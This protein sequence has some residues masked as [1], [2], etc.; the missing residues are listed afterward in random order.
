MSTDG[1]QRRWIRL[2]FYGMI[3]IVVMAIQLRTPWLTPAHKRVQG[4]AALQ[5][6]PPP[7]LGQANNPQN[8]TQ[9]P[10]PHTTTP[11]PT[12]TH[13]PTPVPPTATDTPTPPS[14]TVTDT[15]TPTDTHTRIPTPP[16]PATFTATPQSPT[17]TPKQRGSDGTR[18]IVTLIPW[19]TTPVPAA[20]STPP[21]LIPVTFTPTKTKT[22]DVSPITI[23]PTPP[24][25]ATLTPQLAP[26]TQSPT[27][28]TPVTFT[29]TPPLLPTVTPSPSVVLGCIGRFVPHDLAHVTTVESLQIGLFEAL[30]AGVAVSDLDN[31]DDLDI[32]LGGHD[33][34]DTILWNEGNLR[35]RW[36]PFGQGGT[37]A[38]NAVDV[39]GDGWLD[40][41]LTRHN[42]AVDFWRSLGEA[43]VD[44]GVIGTSEQFVLAV[45]PGIIAPA[46]AMSWGDLDGD[47]DLDLITAAY[48]AESV[49]N[50][51]AGGVMV[52]EHQGSSFAP[53]VL[54]TDTV[55]LALA[56]FDL[57]ADGQLDILV[58]NDGETPDQVWLRSGV[59]WSEGTPLAET[60]F[61]MRSFDWDDLDNDGSDELFT[62]DSNDGGNTLLQRRG[63]TFNNGAEVWGV[64]ATGWSWSGQFGDF[65]NDGY[66]D[67]YVVNG[68]ISGEPPGELVQENQVFRGV[69]GKGFAPMPEWELNSTRGGRGMV[70]ADMDNDG[71]LDI[72]INN[73]RSPALLYENRLCH[74]DYLEVDL[75][76]PQRGNSHGIGA[77]LTL[78]TDGATYYRE[79]RA[80]SAYLSGDP[81]RVHFGFPTGAQLQVLEIR[82][83]DGVV[84]SVEDLQPNT[85][86][87]AE[88]EP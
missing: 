23:E 28:P 14:P 36:M 27:P 70:I 30:G 57:N 18:M 38:V 43:A 47:G 40:I 75:V 54:S 63:A 3:L 84:T 24:T 48:S 44:N 51:D 72:V 29:P 52:Y 73:L 61:R 11:P 20:T 12:A 79:A 55:G 6:V 22:P 17:E 15:P 76:W 60:G 34:Q 39:D 37:R 31:D 78:F 7:V 32:I 65:E 19:P 80:S 56:L 13:T 25:P 86:I 42:G 2:A 88:R 64:A 41:V 46:F 69:D 33:G 83:P 45:L 10:E 16:T 71:D 50:E 5:W 49:A 66:L 26:P 87:E 68:M 74:E 21:P 77:R 62:T 4:N 9:T 59:T 85:F 35:F 1:F 82:W 53:T 58:G 67:L 81:A 8:L